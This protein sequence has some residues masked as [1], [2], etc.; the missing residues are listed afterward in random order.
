M[1]GCHGGNHLIEVKDG[2][3]PPSKRKLTDDEAEW[4]SLWRGRVVVINSVEEA[5]EW[6]NGIREA[7][8]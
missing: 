7:G 5:V 4:H 8:L 2:N 6:L 3:K 1:V